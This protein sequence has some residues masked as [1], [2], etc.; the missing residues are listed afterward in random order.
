[1]LSELSTISILVRVPAQ[2]T[3]HWLAR[4]CRLQAIDIRC[5]R[6]LNRRPTVVGWKAERRNSARLLRLFNDALREI[7]AYV[8]FGSPHFE[9]PR[10]AGS[11][12]E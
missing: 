5:H 7:A 1:M 6:S 10:I 9:M 3:G 8:K 12:I 2:N 11:D 4:I